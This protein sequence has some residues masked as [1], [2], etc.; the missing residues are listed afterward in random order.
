MRAR[1]I[2]DASPLLI[3]IDQAAGRLSVGRTK[4]YEL[5]GEGR[6]QLVKI[7]RATRVV[8]ASI[9]TLIH[10]AVSDQQRSRPPK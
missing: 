4:I 2:S 3:T 9:E 7:D 6:L 10:E 5:A 8:V 1:K